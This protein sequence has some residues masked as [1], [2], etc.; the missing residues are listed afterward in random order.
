MK[1]WYKLVALMIPVLITLGASALGAVAALGALGAAGVAMGGLGILGYGD[2][3]A[4]SMD[5]FKRDLNQ[6]KREI[7]GVL[8]PVGNVFQPFTAGLLDRIPRQIQKMVDPLQRLDEVGMDTFWFE[9]LDGMGDWVADLVDLTSDLSVEIQAIGWAIGR[10]FGSQSLNAIKWFVDELYNNW[11]AVVRVIGSLIS[12]VILIY[13][14]SKAFTFALSVFKPIFD[15]LAGLSDLLDN[16]LTVSLLSGVSAMIAM[17][18]ALS[19]VAGMMA[20]IKGMAVAQAF[21]AAVTAVG[22]LS[23]ALTLLGGI[24]SFI[25]AELGMINAL[26]G[27][28]LLLVGGAI[29]YAAYTGYS[30]GISGDGPGRRGDGYSPPAARGGGGTEIN[31]YGNVGNAEY[32]KLRDAYPEMWQEQSRIDRNTTK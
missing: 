24:L 31:I 27:G 14:V 9:A 2:N 5:R 11:D 19:A 20:V 26:T 1:K 28:L 15:L 4:Q 25:I 8:K 6:M 22:S 21:W 30:G 13:N 32:Q 18:F 29:T 7:A 16:R 10:A 17:Y 23:G 12:L 3:M